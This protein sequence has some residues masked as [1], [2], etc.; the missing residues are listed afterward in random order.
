M[1]WLP[2]FMPREA[3]ESTLWAAEECPLL[4]VPVNWSGTRTVYEIWET[5]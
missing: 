2:Y 5:F 3:A 1:G 4:S